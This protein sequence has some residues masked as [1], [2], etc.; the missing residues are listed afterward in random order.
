MFKA[1]DQGSLR[2]AFSGKVFRG[3]LERK[4]SRA[5]NGLTAVGVNVTRVVYAREIHPN[6]RKSDELEY[7]LFGKDEEFFLAHRI[8]QGP[9][10][11]HIVGAKI[12]GRD[13]TAAELKAGIAVKIPN[14]ENSAAERLKS[15]ETV[16][17]QGRVGGAD[18][19]LALQITVGTEHYFEEGE[20]SSPANFE[21]TPLEKKAGF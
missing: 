5:I 8:T 17:G 3:H 12:S 19:V 9:D 1:D 16:A 21:Q 13:F 2:Q 14:R 15:N 4:G 7:I 10:F 6:D 20:L 18:Q 11:D